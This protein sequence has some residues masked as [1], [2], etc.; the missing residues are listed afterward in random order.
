[1]TAGCRSLAANPLVPPPA[2]SPAVGQFL[3]HFGIDPR[4]RPDEL[5]G[6]IT[7]AFARLPYENLSK[8][9]KLSA[10]GV[11]QRARRGPDEVVADH[12]ALGAG[13][14]CF[15]LTA[16]LLHI[17]RALGFVAEP[18]LADRHYGADTHC[19]LLVWLEGQPHLI[20]PGYLIVDPIPLAG[21][22]EYRRPTGFNEIILRSQ[23]GGGQIALATRAGGVSSHRLTFKVTPADAGQFVRAWD[24]S[25]DWDMMHYPVL[26]RVVEGRQLYLQSA[27]LQV[28]G[29]EETRRAEISPDALPEIIVHQ[30]GIH[31]KLVR[32]ALDV[33]AGE[34]RQHGNSLRA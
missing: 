20:D 10:T 6:Q 15:S 2:G 34:R 19:A 14:T 12:I 24:A 27:R 29:G 13:G 30:F 16:A 17:L 3:E 23:G 21:L 33:L 22:D 26:T 7:R 32:R 25:F 1:M 5:L 8:I 9:L 31:P 18:I 11:A 28:R 4:H